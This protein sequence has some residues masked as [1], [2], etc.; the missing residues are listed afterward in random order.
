VIDAIRKLLRERDYV[1]FAEI[2]RLPGAEGKLELALETDDASN[3]VLW[4]GLSPAAFAALKTM[5]ANGD[6]HFVPASLISYLVDDALLKLPLAKE[7]RHYKKPHWLP[8]TLR[9]GR[10]AA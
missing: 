8:L 5:L 1:S 7:A 4:R 10:E 3:I 6:C 9:P 2:A